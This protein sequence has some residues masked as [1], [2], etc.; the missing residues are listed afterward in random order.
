MAK[1]GRSL[2]VLT[3]IGAAAAGTYYYLKKKDEEVPANM[4][5]DDFDNF[6]EEGEGAPSK[7]KRSYVN[8]DFNTV[9]EKAKDFAG[10]AADVATKAADSISSFIS[11]AEGKVEEFFDDR[12]SADE[13]SETPAESGEAS[14]DDYEE[15][16][17]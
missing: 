12:K 10:K 8:L 16:K 2:L 6:G 5:D 7:S 1:L 17:E 13:E 3:A 14:E 15:P 9:E 11:Q 4:E